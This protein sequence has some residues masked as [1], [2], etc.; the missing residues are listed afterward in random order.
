MQQARNASM[1]MEDQGINLK[2]LIRDRDR[3]Y[4][5]EF[6]VFWKDA[7]VRPIRIPPRAPMANAF[8]ETYIG[9]M[10]Q[11]VLN[12]FFCFGLDQLDYINRVWLKHYHEQRPHRGVGRDNTVLDQTFVPET[13]GIVRCKTELGG[14]LKSYYRDAA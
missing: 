11:E 5:D 1:W 9:K 8:V 6:D 10:K 13:E 12:H 3:K 14:I 4:P 7:E 2:F